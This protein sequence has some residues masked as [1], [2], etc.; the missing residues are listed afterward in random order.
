MPPF[1]AKQGPID[2]NGRPNSFMRATDKTRRVILPWTLVGCLALLASVAAVVGVR[3]DKSPAV[4]GVNPPPVYSLITGFGG[5]VW[6]G[7]VD[8]IDAE[9]RVPRIIGAGQNAAES[10]WI[11]AQGTSADQPFIQLGTAG[12]LASS[13]FLSPEEPSSSSIS[14]SQPTQSTYDV[15]WSDTAQHFRPITL[16]RLR[17]PGDLI[18][19]QMRKQGNGWRLSVRNVTAGWSQSITVPYGEHDSFSEAS[20]LQE[21]PGGYTPGTDAPYAQTST[22]T[23]GR[24]KVDDRT[25]RLGYANER[26]LST[27]DDVYLVPTA[28][29]ND[30]FSMVSASGAARQYLS[31]AQQLDSAITVLAI[32]MVGWNVHSD[33]TPNQVRVVKQMAFLY[34]A[35]AHQLASQTWPSQAR[36]QIERLVAIQLHVAKA[37]GQWASSPHPAIGELR[38]ISGFDPGERVVAEVRHVLGLPPI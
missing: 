6:N 9:W 35:A 15:F 25:P 22:I 17:H 24:L 33:A 5:Y 14:P 31:D 34:G 29:T 32:K 4:K 27:Q 12:Y 36:G 18:S 16:V 19:F 1:A 13:P 26:A 21:D 3:G 2:P 11:G 38:T 30:G 23:M 20:W 28:V 8:E 7:P 37:V 10:T